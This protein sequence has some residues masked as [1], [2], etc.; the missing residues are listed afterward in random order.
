MGRKW[1]GLLNVLP[2]NHHAVLASEKMRMDPVTTKLTFTLKEVQG[3]A[4]HALLEPAATALAA[5]AVP[6]EVSSW[7]LGCGK[8]SSAAVAAY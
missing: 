3:M 8:F 5:P 2:S 4:C 6:E 1:V 7:L